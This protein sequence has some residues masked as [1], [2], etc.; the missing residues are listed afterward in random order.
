[1]VQVIEKERQGGLGRLTQLVC[2]TL[3]SVTIIALKVYTLGDLSNQQ[4][5]FET[6]VS[7]NIIN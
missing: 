5:V 3:G 4:T 1:M 2:I 7:K 6:I